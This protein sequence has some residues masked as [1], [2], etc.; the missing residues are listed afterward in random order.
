MIDSQSVDHSINHS[1]CL[2]HCGF[3][4]CLSWW[5]WYFLINL[6]PY[7]CYCCWI[8]MNT[9]TNRNNPN[10]KCWPF[11]MCFSNSCTSKMFIVNKPFM[12]SSYVP[13]SIP[14]FSCANHQMIRITYPGPVWSCFTLNPML[15]HISTQSS[16]ISRLH[17]VDQIKFL[18]NCHRLLSPSKR[19]WENNKVVLYAKVIKIAKW[20]VVASGISVLQ[21][22]QQVSRKRAARVG[23]YNWNGRRQK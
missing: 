19:F 1:I 15:G 2:F 9:F 14:K 22:V 8:P 17:F 7:I 5:V 11:W 3:K 21:P 12:Y 18:W 20:T 23:F 4:W 13:T 6:S 16:S 10:I